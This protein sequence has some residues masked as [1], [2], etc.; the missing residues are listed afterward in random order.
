MIRLTLMAALLLAAACGTSSD[1][2]GQQQDVS[3]GCQ[4]FMSGAVMA[5]GV[6]SCTV[7][8][9]SAPDAGVSF[10][11]TS[12]GTS[13]GTLS[14]AAELPG[15]TFATGAF[16]TSG[17][18][19]AL[20]AAT[21]LTNGSAIWLQS[22]HGPDPDTGSMSLT[23]QSTGTAV[24]AKGATAWTGPSGQLKATLIPQAASGASGTVT[25]TI[26]F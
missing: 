10:A 17:S 16:G 21:T 14:F 24:T 26:D 3:N 23:V 15:S 18:M 6:Q 19:A 2:Q 22:L 20:K 4:I 8:A 12:S 7:A 13:Y 9:A 25:A 5:T 1:T 11:V